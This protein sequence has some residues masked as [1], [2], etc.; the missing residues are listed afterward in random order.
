[1]QRDVADAAP[2]PGG[3]T[4]AAATAPRLRRAR[5]MSS[6]ARHANPPSTT[7]TR[8]C[9]RHQP[10]LGV[11]PRRARR[12]FLRVS[13]CCPAA[14]TGRRPTTRV[15]LSVNPSAAS[16]LSGALASPAR[17]N[18][19]NRKSP[20]P[21]AGEHPTGPVRTVRR[22]R[23]PERCQIRGVLR[24]EAGNRPD[25]ST[26]RRHR[27]D[28][29]PAPTSSRHVTN[30][31]HARQTLT[32]ASRSRRP[33]RRASRRTGRARASSRRR[34]RVDAGS[35]GQPVPAG[36]GESNSTPVRGCGRSTPPLCTAGQNL[37]RRGRPRCYIRRDTS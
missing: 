32:A 22:R 24:P 3:R 17:C 13:A 23:Q 26:A 4:S 6:A 14:H 11:Q 28:A 30:R 12:P 15:S 35:P 37:S 5:T 2:T 29:S 10:P 25:P 20:R 16:T 21:V 19:A 27:T 18:A 34:C 36:T 31:G 33:T 8:T 1:M 9:G 7:I